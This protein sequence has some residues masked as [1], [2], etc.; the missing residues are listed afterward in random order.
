MQVVPGANSG[1]GSIR[2]DNNFQDDIEAASSV[3]ASIPNK[4]RNTFN[5]WATRNPGQVYALYN[6]VRSPIGAGGSGKCEAVYCNASCAAPSPA[7]GGDVPSYGS[8]YI[9]RPNCPQNSY[10]SGCWH[11]QHGKGGNSGNGLI[12][13]NVS[14]P[15]N[16]DSSIKLDETDSLGGVT[17]TT[18]GNTNSVVMM[19]SGAGGTPVFNSAA[20][21]FTNGAN[22]GTPASCKY[23]GNTNWCSRA[24]A[25][26]G[27]QGAAYGI[28]VPDLQTCQDR[29]VPTVFGRVTYKGKG[30][31]NGYNNNAAYTW[32]YTDPD[33]IPTI[34]KRGE[35]GSDV[36]QVFNNI[37]G[38]LQLHPA[39]GTGD[40]TYVAKDGQ[41]IV[42][43]LNPSNPNGGRFNTNTHYKVNEQI[44]QGI[45]ELGKP[46]NEDHFTY[47]DAIRSSGFRIPLLNCG[48]NCPGYAGTG[49]YL[50]VKDTNAINFVRLINRQSGNV[51]YDK[52][53]S[54][55]NNFDNLS[56]CPDGD[57][58]TSYPNVAWAAY[59]SGSKRNGSWGGVIVIW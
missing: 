58:M 47:L 39:R 54:N 14:V 41:R 12:V 55:F 31:G 59:C 36:V 25:V 50:F 15:I 9:K 28:E 45:A 23:Q 43:A 7:R 26:A 37:K 20:G 32:E 56:T 22:N 17:V 52:Y 5:E 27:N 6:E 1:S 10:T 13:R 3:D 33:V 24:S 18:N 53:F 29:E 2:I 30:L 57:I 48:K 8:W 4:I 34:T 51:T 35:Y 44:P 40:T 16:G 42:S 49:T 21:V 11:Y 19:T 46:E 38:T